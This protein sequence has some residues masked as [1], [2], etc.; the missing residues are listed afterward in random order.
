[1]SLWGVC[2][3][4]GQKKVRTQLKSHRIFGLIC[5]ESCKKSEKQ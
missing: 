2:G 4:C 3:R 5:I 1:M